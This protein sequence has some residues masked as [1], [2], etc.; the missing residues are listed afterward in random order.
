[1][2]NAQITLVSSTKHSEYDQEISQSQTAYKSMSP[3][4][5]AAQVQSLTGT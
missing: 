3:R 4:G 5:R 2:L 1:M